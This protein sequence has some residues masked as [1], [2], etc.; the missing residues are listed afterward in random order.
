MPPSWPT[1]DELRLS[2]IAFLINGNGY[3]GDGMIGVLFFFKDREP[4]SDR[5]TR[6]VG[7]S[8]VDSVAVDLSGHQLLP[9][10][11]RLF[12]DFQGEL[13][14]ASLGVEGE[15]VLRLAVGHFVDA[16][17]LDGGLQEAGH[18]LLDVSDVC[19]NAI[20]VNTGRLRRHPRIGSYR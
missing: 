4:M 17:P 13:A 2:E 11:V 18:V 14:V 1:N 16:E 7:A 5:G 12:D 9:V 19:A 6:R 10:V 15:L 3:G 20:H 8:P